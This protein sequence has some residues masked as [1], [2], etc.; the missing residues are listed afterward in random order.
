MR[1][2]TQAFLIRSQQRVLEGYRRV[3]ETWPDM[4]ADERRAIELRLARAEA[5]L[6]GFL[7]AA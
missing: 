4:P 7:Q 2:E 6:D 1:S 5:Q 3:L